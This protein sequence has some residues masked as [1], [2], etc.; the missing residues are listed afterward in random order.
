MML[1][2]LLERFGARCLL[3]NCNY[4]VNIVAVWRFKVYQ[5]QKEKDQ[6][7]YASGVCLGATEETKEGCFPL[8]SPSAPANSYNHQA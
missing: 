5:A 4:I 8:A 2:T 7:G 3:N 6:V 1:H